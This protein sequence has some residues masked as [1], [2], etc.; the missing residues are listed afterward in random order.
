MARR[1][2]KI[3]EGE[4]TSTSKIFSIK[5]PVPSPLLFERDFF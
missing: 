4:A 5:T 3:Q 2:K 1:G